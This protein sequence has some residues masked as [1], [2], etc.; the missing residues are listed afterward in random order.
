M[1]I[2]K[3]IAFTLIVVMLF[4]LTIS[5]LADTCAGTRDYSASILYHQ[6]TFWFTSNTGHYWSRIDD[7]LIMSP[8]WDYDISV[9]NGVAVV[10][11]ATRNCTLL[12]YTERYDLNFVDY[13]TKKIGLT[14]YNPWD[15]G[16]SNF[17]IEGSFKPYYR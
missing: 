6:Y 11:S 7:T 12:N 5:T 15:N 4:G 1:K 14:V 13:T 16:E 2:K 17:P 8:D 3:A 9:T 10:Y